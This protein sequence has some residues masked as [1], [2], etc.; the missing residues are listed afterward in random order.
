MNVMIVIY[1][2]SEEDNVICIIQVSES[3]QWETSSGGNSLH[4][5]VNCTAEQSR[6]ENAALSDTGGG[7]ETGTAA[8]RLNPCA[9]NFLEADL[10]PA[11]YGHTL[12]LGEAVNQSQH[13]YYV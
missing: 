3:A 6:S 4:N 11:L 7:D 12:Y 5:P 2:V 1:F 10:M 8:T 13:I 9:R